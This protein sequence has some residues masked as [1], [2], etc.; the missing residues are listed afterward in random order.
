M[1]LLP[2]LPWLLGGLTVIYVVTRPS[3]PAPAPPSSTCP[4]LTPAKRALVT[5]ILDEDP[6]ILLANGS[7]QG[8]SKAD[9]VSMLQLGA[10]EMTDL[11]C[12]LE[13]AKLR[14][15]A[16]V[17]AALPDPNP[18]QLPGG[19]I[20]MGVPGTPG[21]TP[22]GTPAGG[23]APSGPVLTPVPAT[24]PIQ[25]GDLAILP[26]VTFLGKDAAG[27]DQLQ[28]DPPVLIPAGA[29]RVRVS[30]ADT[31]GPGLI[32]T[33]LLSFLDSS[34]KNVPAVVPGLE[35]KLGVDPALLA[36]HRYKELK[37]S[38]GRTGAAAGRSP[39]ALMRCGLEGCSV[40]PEP[41]A[42]NDA[43]GRFGFTIP[44]DYPVGI[45]GMGPPGW[46][47]VELHHPDHGL[48]D[49]WIEAAHL[50]PAAPAVPAAQTSASL[51]GPH[52]GT[53]VAGQRPLP[54]GL[55]PFPP[56]FASRAKS[57]SKRMSRRA[58]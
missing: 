22:G 55:S 38:T 11:G 32:G 41:R 21:G 35:P 8:A 57:K 24:E 37:T 52:A 36:T 17:I 9:L 33:K 13:A 16:V 28:S 25:V 20:D 3:T 56:A 42:W 45:I 50:L 40:R 34:G 58:S 47:R 29:N 39:M 15:K 46:V 31:A 18:A 1:P 53:R 27:Q 5:Y 49:G 7:G 2:L 23:T 51:Y 6:R 4:K 26:V 19:G 43:W 10:Q 30:V 48:I 44:Q 12:P 54:P 14:E